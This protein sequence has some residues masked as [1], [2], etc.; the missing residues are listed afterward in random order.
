[1]VLGERK[2]RKSTFKIHVGDNWQN[3]VPGYKGERS[4]EDAFKILVY[5]L[6]PSIKSKLAKGRLGG[7]AG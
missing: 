1:M 5:L 4:M 7:S 2:G 3:K 6:S